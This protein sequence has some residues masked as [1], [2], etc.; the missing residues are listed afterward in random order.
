MCVCVCLSVCE[1]IEVCE[2]VCVG[3]VSGSAVHTCM[4]AV[5]ANCS[6]GDYARDLGVSCAIVK[7]PYLADDGTCRRGRESK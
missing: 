2:C 6:T 1:G 7:K 5:I 3:G 4:T